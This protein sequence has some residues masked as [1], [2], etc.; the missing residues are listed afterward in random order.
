MNIQSGISHKE[1]RESKRI[2]LRGI[3]KTFII[4]L[5]IILQIRLIVLILYVLQKQVPW[6]STFITYATMVVLLYGLVIMVF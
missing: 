3:I 2:H 1:V 5:L 4:L 6:L